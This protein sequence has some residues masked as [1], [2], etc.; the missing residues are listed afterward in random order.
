MN[1]VMDYIKNPSMILAHFIRGKA[2]WMPDE[3][4]LKIL[5]KANLGKK[6]NLINPTTYTEK[7]QWLKLYDRKDIYTQMVDK[8][9]VK[10]FVAERIGD[11]FVVPTIGVFDNFDDIDFNLLPNKFVIKCTHDSHSIIV[12]RDK[13]K[14]DIDAA[15]KKLNICLQRNYFWLGREWPYKNVKPRIIVEKMLCEDPSDHL[16][17]Y[18]FF[19]FNGEP[20]IV[21]R[22][23][24]DRDRNEKHY[25]DFYSIDG[26][27][28]PFSW[29]YPISEDGK[30]TK[31]EVYYEMLSLCANL[32]KGL[33]FIRVDFFRDEE[34]K[35][36]VG[37]LTFYECSGLTKL[38]PT[39]W[40]E[41]LGSWIQLPHIEKR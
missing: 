10:Q 36:Y 17:E 6:L 21:C 31:D 12:C 29:C 28:Q 8:Y 5:Y 22:C 38:T 40:D 18:D 25:N 24:G 35:I 39:K 3:L 34:D 27:R 4:Y 32:S 7:M 20:K 13:A 9:G 14:F 16:E 41:T 11:K 23:W 2:Q 30:L 15:R 1:K 33:P 37:E 26:E 19:C